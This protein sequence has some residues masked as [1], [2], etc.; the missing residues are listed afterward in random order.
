[1]K[2]N[3][4]SE[5]TE[6]ERNSRLAEAKVMRVLDHQN[7]AK[8]K[9][10]YKTKSGKLVTVMEYIQGS[11]LKQFIK[12]QKEYLSE[13][14]I[15]HLFTQI[16]LGLK[17]MHDRKLLFRDF[18]TENI[19]LNKKGEVKLR[20]LNEPGLG[21][22]IAQS[23]ISAPYRIQPE[24]LQSLPY[25]FKSDIWSLGIVL[26]MLCALQTPFSSDN[27]ED[28]LLA[29]QSGEFKE[30]PSQY[31][32]NVHKLIK[33]LLLVLILHLLLKIGLHILSR[34]FNLILAYLLLLLQILY[35]L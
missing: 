15:L 1:M 28:T 27:L 25:S 7:I 35:H 11:S 30:I 24:I 10:V 19:L 34:C 6:L 4:I 3:D 2:E 17:H 22:R 26:Y 21:N 33:Q 14:R 13:N 8:I 5:L 31:S 9:E 32:A 23:M 29:V 16:A 18:K 12:K 20:C